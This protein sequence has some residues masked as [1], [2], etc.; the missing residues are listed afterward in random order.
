MHGR[1]VWQDIRT[2]AAK[3]HSYEKLRADGLISIGI[4]IGSTSSDLVIVNEKNNI[5]FSDY[6]RTMGK[7][8]ETILQ[9]LRNIK[10]IVRKMR[11]M[12]DAP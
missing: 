12:V 6:Q 10:E 1:T 8:V 9:Q 3:H 4:D 7:P 11:F 5:I 2:R